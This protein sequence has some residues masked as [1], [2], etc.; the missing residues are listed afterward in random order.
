MLIGIYKDWIWIKVWI[1][2]ERLRF[3]NVIVVFV[4]IDEVDRIYIGIVF[5]MILVSSVC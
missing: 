1:V 3:D 4:F 5:K 2:M